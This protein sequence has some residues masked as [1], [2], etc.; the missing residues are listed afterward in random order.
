MVGDECL[1]GYS[2]K[3]LKPVKNVASSI[4]HGIPKF[5]IKIFELENLRSNPKKLEKNYKKILIKTNCA[6]TPYSNI[7]LTKCHAL[8]ITL[9]REN[10]NYC[11]L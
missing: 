5:L 11:R 6:A 10:K 1:C 4:F 8:V 9:A 3:I 7:M 2:H